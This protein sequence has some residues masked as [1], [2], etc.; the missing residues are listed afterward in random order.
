MALVATDGQGELTFYFE[1]AGEDIGVH[2][3]EDFHDVVDGGVGELQ[4]QGNVLGALDDGS[5]GNGISGSLAVGLYEA[6]NAE[7]DTP[8]IANDDDEDVGEVVGNDLP[9]DGFPG[10]GGGF[11]VVDGPKRVA[12]EAKGVGVAMVSGVVVF[13]FQ[14]GKDVLNLVLGLDGV[15]EGEETAAFV[16]IGALGGLF[17]GEVGVFAVH[18]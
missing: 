9:Q 4:V 7:F 8:E 2:V 6:G 3:L 15:D 11:P 10:R 13:R 17:D 18:G 16:F 14:G 5:V 12:M 1:L